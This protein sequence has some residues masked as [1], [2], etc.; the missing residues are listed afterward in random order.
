MTSPAHLRYLD[1]ITHSVWAAL[2]LHVAFG[3]FFALT[4]FRDL[5]LFNAGSVALY[6]LLAFQLRQGRFTVTLLLTT[7]EVILHARLALSALGFESGFQYYVFALIPAA[8]FHPHWRLPAKLV[9]LAGIA[10]AYATLDLAPVTQAGA[11]PLSPDTLLWVRT[12]NTFAAFGFVA[13]VTGFYSSVARQAE[14]ELAQLATLDPLTGLYNRRHMLGMVE[15]ELARLERSGKPATLL[16]ADIDNFKGINDQHGH[17]CGD[18]A[19]KQIARC[20]R[21]VMRRQ[22][23]IARWG[24]EEFLLLLPETDLEGARVLADKLRARLAGKPL[25]WNDASLTFTLTAAI[26]QLQPG[27]DF[28][29]ALS[30]VDG[31]LLQ[32]KREGKDCVVTVSA[33]GEPTG[34][35][36][37]RAA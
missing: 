22:D 21:T 33:L 12:F 19:L 7:V 30:A 23:H 25:N 29:A 34:P 4:G 37:A 17:E 32:G 20:L 26:A 2:A 5:A 1:L 31:G 35:Q 10:A 15:L 27:D 36:V 28:L 16:M 24:G 11:A 14:N 18:L 13:Y 8:F 6:A 9:Y 3:V